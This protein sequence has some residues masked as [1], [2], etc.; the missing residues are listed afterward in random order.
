MFSKLS[1]CR[2]TQTEPYFMMYESG[3]PNI[4][5]EIYSISF[6]KILNDV[7]TGNRKGIIRKMDS[8]SILNDSQSYTN[9]NHAGFHVIYAILCQIRKLQFYAEPGQL[10]KE[11]WSVIKIVSVIYEDLIFI[12]RIEYLRYHITQC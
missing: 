7:C 9:L 6:L 3:I 11:V 4:I 10:Q 2:G 5:R 1:Q 12:L 8:I